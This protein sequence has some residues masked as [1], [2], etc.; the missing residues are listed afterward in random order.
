VSDSNVFPWTAPTV[1]VH[2][3][4]ERVPGFAAVVVLRGEHDLE[5]RAALEEA[6]E[7]IFG[8]VLLDLTDCRF[9]DS[10]V[11]GV[12][13]SEALALRREGHRLEL[14]VPPANRQVTRVIDLIGLRELLVVHDGEPQD[15]PP[16]SVAGRLPV[17]TVTRRGP[18]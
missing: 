5:T 17:V 12:V 10:S 6:L 2:Y 18:D 4:A 11:I 7:P 16:A 15:Q 3:D 9:I 8:S 1:E 13:V 14:I